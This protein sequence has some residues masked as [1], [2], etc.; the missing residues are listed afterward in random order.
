MAETDV[1]VESRTPT[2]DMDIWSDE[3]LT[4]PYP[5]YRQ[6]RDL[7]PAVWLTKHGVWV[8]PR[9][10]S[11]REALLNWEVF[12]SKNGTAMNAVMNQ[13]VDG[14]LLLSGEPEH[15]RLRRT[16]V[17]PLQPQTLKKL[18]DRLTALAE[19]RVEE[20]LGKGEFDA[21][22]D[23][24]QFLPLSV[25][26]E[27]LGLGEEGK[28]HM[29]RWG[30][31]LFD[32]QGP[33]GYPRTIAGLEVA[34]EAFTY[35]SNIKRSELDPEGWGAALFNAADAGELSYQE[36]RYMLLDYTAPAL[37]TTINGFSSTFY[38]LGRNP[39][40][41]ETLRQNPER[42]PFAIDEALRMESPIR[43]FTRTLTRD[44][45][46]EGVEMKEGDRA[47]MLSAAANRDERHYP[48]PDSYDIMRD[49]RDHVAFG[50][51]I[52]MCAGRHLGKLEITTVFKVL[53]K[54]LKSFE[55]IE[56]RRELQNNLRGLAKL[57]IR[58]NPL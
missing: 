33:D 43:L 49:S 50:Y 41:W 16:F 56:E 46:L 31:G 54:R 9:Y 22:A 36:A 7:G 58:A 42:L 53:L 2:S 13:A 29:L 55:I 34:K 20:L 8:V 48:D 26:T 12:T 3:V 17:K 21:V 25:V 38:M 37:D 27:L 47:I 35:L 30:A 51:G 45:D 44:F 5:Y 14:I 15:Q 4:N 32:G 39:D 57:V 1:L 52:H 24:A 6:L 10:S 23:L 11:I 40:Q 18:Q 19:Q 28:K